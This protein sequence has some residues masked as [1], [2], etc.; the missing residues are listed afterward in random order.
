MAAHAEPVQDR[1]ADAHRLVGEHGHPLAAIAQPVQRFAHAGIQRG[2]VQVVLAI[3]FQEEFERLLDFQFAGLRA[4]RPADQ[5]RGAVAH[6]G[7]DA[8]VIERAHAHMGTRGVD[9]VRQ[10]QFGIDQRAVQVED[11]Q[12]HD[13]A[14]PVFVLRG[15]TARAIG[16]R[17][18]SAQDEDGHRV[19][20]D[21]LIFDLDGTLIDSK[22]DLAHAVNATRS[23][24]GMSPLDHER[25]YS[26]V[27]NGA[28]VL[29]RRAM[30]EQATELDVEE[31]LEF[32]LEYYREH[33]LDYTTLYP[34]VRE[35]LDRLRDGGKRMAVLTNKPC[36][37]YTS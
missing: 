7:V 24:M 3:V 9:G 8:L 22:L 30:G 21:L 35:A 10:V 11:Q 18:E 31:A 20:M 28:P 34:G 25:V 32:F 33:Y 13:Y 4:H 17:R 26:Y 36:L 2:V 1:A 12:V 15:F 14:V 5:H 37:L 16:L 27:G 6:V 23:H 19:V 29:I